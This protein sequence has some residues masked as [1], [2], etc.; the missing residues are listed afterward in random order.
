MRLSDLTA[1]LLIDGQAHGCSKLST[2]LGRV[3]L[4][5]LPATCTT[6][7]TPQSRATFEDIATPGTEGFLAGSFGK[8]SDDE[9]ETDP[10]F[11][12]TA[13]EKEQRYGQARYATAPHIA[14]VTLAAP[15]LGHAS[16]LWQSGVLSSTGAG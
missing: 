13:T 2:K 3:A 6:R 8:M 4:C 12:N 9:W 10:D 11:E 14:N 1:F 16:P 5:S 7:R 15:F